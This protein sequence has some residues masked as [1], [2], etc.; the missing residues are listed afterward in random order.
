MLKRSFCALLTVLMAML[1]CPG[2]VC[3]GEE[4]NLIVNGSF[5]VLDE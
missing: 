1:F 5:E 2:A 3:A 4:D